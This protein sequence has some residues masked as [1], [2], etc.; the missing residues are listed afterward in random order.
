MKPQ[1]PIHRMKR[2]AKQRARAKKIPLHQAL[3]DIA[4]NAGA[5]SWSLLMHQRKTALAVEDP[6]RVRLRGFT[7]AVLENVI[8]RMEPDHPEFV[9]ELWDVDA[10]LD[11]H[12][13]RDAD[14]TMDIDEAEHLI[15][16]TLWHH[17]VDFAVEADKLASAQ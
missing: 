8:P 4:H 14:L 11:N 6:R 3:D 12:Y 15:E 17:I 16:A 9:R 7:N 13:F 1:L 2:L 10:Y 5:A